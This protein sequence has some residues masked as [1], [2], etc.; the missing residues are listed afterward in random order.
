MM[1][2]RAASDN[3]SSLKPRPTPVVWEGHMTSADTLQRYSRIA[4]VAMLL[5]IVF[6]ALGEAYLPGR[7]IVSGDATATAANIVNHPTLFRLTFASYLVEGLC[8]ILLCV[9]FY[10]LLKPV[11]RNLALISAFFGI[12]SMVTFAIAESAFFASSFIVRDINGMGSFTAEQRNALAYLS[13][14][15]STMI[16]TLFLICYGTAT[17]IRGWLMMQ[18]DYFPKWIGILLM[19][20]G[21]GFFLRTATYLLAPSLSSTVMLIPMAIGGIPLMLWLLIKGIRPAANPL[22]AAAAR[23]G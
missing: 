2:P 13:L 12:A 14:R 20:G 3:R 4:G 5:S 8:D 11:N 7:I 6:G 17:M 1:R 19:I 21:A 16:A 18:S 10:I 23:A 15:I 9:V 22:V